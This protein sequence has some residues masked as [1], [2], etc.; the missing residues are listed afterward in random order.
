MNASSLLTSPRFGRAIR[1]SL[2]FT[3]VAIILKFVL[4]MA[5]ALV[6]NR[7]FF[8]RNILRAY[9]LVPW[10][11]PVVVN[12]Q[13]WFSPSEKS[14][15]FAAPSMAVGDTVGVDPG[16]VHICPVWPLPFSPQ[17][18]RVPSSASARWKRPAE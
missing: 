5:M 16:E 14:A 2:I 9:F 12:T 8:G 15:T 3:I 17:H 7:A 11:L 1:Q 13:V 4:G 18:R 10:V 6:L